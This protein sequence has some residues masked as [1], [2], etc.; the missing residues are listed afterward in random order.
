MTTSNGYRVIVDFED[1]PN[2][3]DKTWYY[4][5]R[6]VVT[7]QR[8]PVRRTLSMHRFIMQTPLGKVTDHINGDRLDNRRSNLRICSQADNCRGFKSV[9]YNSK[10]GVTGVHPVKTTIKWRDRVYTYSYW[11]VS[12]NG[13]SIG[14][15]KTLESA[16]KLRKESHALLQTT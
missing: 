9:R 1:Y 6:Y 14:T 7:T 8:K 3:K 13:K 10:S 15:R 5:G 16:I 2:L 12:L 11:A 4:D